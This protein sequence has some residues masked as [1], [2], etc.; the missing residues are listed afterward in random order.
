MPA[1]LQSPSVGTA[2][3]FLNMNILVVRLQS[4]Y[5]HREKDK[6]KAKNKKKTKP[7]KVKNCKY[8]ARL[9]LYSAM[10]CRIH[11]AKF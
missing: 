6:N 4:S 11:P 9:T 3:S 8:R 7:T 2:L 5:A 10:S 1:D